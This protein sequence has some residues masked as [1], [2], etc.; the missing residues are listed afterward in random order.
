MPFLALRIRKFQIIE[1]ERLILT[2]FAIF[3]EIFTPAPNSTRILFEILNRTRKNDT[4]SAGAGFICK[5][6]FGN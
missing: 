2:R 1:V 4:R 3:F 6:E 5:S